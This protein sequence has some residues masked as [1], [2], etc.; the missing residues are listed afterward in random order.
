MA[1]REYREEGRRA[2][3]RLA[4]GSLGG[5]VE[6]WEEH[7]DP[8][9]NPRLDPEQV[10]V[11]E[12]DG[13]IRAL[14]AVP[15]L[16]VFVDGEPVSMGGIADVAT[17]PAYRRRGYAGEL[18]R[19]ALGGMWER[20]VHLSMLHHFAHAFYRRYGWELATE[21]ISY[22]LKLTDLSTSAGQKRVRAYRDEDLPG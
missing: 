21:A 10:Y 19:A 18:V 1:L 6:G 15:P 20:G 11:V 9:K 4:A 5:S 17:H 2:V 14:A 3:A 16:E 22:R 7:Y 12:E 13:D 8:E